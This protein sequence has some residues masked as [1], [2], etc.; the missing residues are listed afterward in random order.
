M[1][2]ADLVRRPGSMLW[3][4]GLLAGL[5]PSAADA[6]EFPALVDD[7]TAPQVGL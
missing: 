3:R 1:R 5:D 7:F 4:L 2:F 6:L